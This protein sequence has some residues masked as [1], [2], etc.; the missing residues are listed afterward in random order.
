MTK[1]W[2]GDRDSAFFC[3]GCGVKAINGLE[4]WQVWEFCNPGACW[5]SSFEFSSFWA[6]NGCWLP[7]VL[8]IPHPLPLLLAT[9]GWFLLFASKF[10]AVPK[11]FSPALR[12]L[13]MPCPTHALSL[14]PI[15]VAW[16]CFLPQIPRA[17]QDW[18]PLSF[19]F[20]S[21]FHFRFS[22]TASLR[23]SQYL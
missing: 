16:G 5:I 13:T 1:A 12:V 6:V 18:G 8:V 22:S 19:L 14:G 11:P 23:T 20:S 17:P 2:K 10:Q 3:C 21:W 4:L 9:V 15:H 7:S